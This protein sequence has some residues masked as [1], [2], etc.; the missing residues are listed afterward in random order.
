[1]T[2]ALG[3]LTSSF[4][5]AIAVIATAALF[6]RRIGAMRAGAGDSPVD[7][8]ELSMERYRPMLRLLD[9]DD[10]RFLRNQPGATSTLIQRFRKQ[11]CQIFLGYLQCLERDFRRASD[12]L[13]LVMLH[14]QSDR[15][16]LIPALIG[17][18][19]KFGMRLLLVRYRLWLYQ[20][21]LGTEPV[22][23]LVGLVEGLQQQ[24]QALAPLARGVEA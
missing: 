13:I 23:R 17:G 19:L 7:P 21:D 22:G 14:S 15:R 16:D 3:I 20:W 18:R 2:L 24:L 12:G 4:I 9:R 10:I 11:R 6:T 1:M 5:P 8:A